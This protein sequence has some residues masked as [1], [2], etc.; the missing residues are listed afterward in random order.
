MKFQMF[1]WT[2]IAVVLYVILFL[3]NLKASMLQLPGV[4]PSIVIL[5]GVS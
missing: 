4:D 3:D 5:T 2:L 1:G